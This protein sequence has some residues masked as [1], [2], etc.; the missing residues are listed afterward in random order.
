MTNIIEKKLG[1]KQ[2]LAFFSSNRLTKEKNFVRSLL[3]A[4]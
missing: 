4:D 1:G 3:S 2:K